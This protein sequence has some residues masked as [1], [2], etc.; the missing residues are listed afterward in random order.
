MNKE[1]A[2]S[3]LAEILRNEDPGALTTKVAEGLGLTMDH[4]LIFAQMPKHNQMN[5][6]RALWLKAATNA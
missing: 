2:I 1:E 6:I 3:K 4:F 5:I